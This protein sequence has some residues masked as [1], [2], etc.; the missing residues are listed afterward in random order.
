MIVRE[1]VAHPEMADNF[2][3]FNDYQDTIGYLRSL[4]ATASVILTTDRLEASY[5]IWFARYFARLKP[6]TEYVP[7]DGQLQ[8]ADEGGETQPGADQIDS[9]NQEGV[10]VSGPHS[11]AAEALAEADA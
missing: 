4:P 3:H 9:Q 2:D 7:K 5:K 10:R 6:H 11:S 8:T 1:I